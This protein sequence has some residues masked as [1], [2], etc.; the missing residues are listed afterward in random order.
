M[1]HTPETVTVAHTQYI[2]ERKALPCVRYSFA[3]VYHLSLILLLCFCL[4]ASAS[5]TPLQARKE[6]SQKQKMLIK[7]KDLRFGPGL[8]TAVISQAQ[9]FIIPVP[10]LDSGGEKLIYP[11]GHKQAGELIKDWQGN[12]VGKTGIVFFNAKD[13]SW[14]AAPGDGNAVIIINEVTEEQGR[15][16]HD[17]IREFR[18]NPDDLSLEELKQILTFAREELRLGD[19]YNSTRQF[20]FEK[21]TPIISGQEPAD[22]KTGKA[23]GLM[24]RDDRDICQ[25][26]YIPGTFVFQGPAASPQ[27]FENGGVLVKQGKDIRGVQPEVF[28]RTYRHANGRSFHNVVEE[29]SAKTP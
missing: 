8:S 21:M 24:K 2:N 16:I 25:A 22:N 4:P 12:P 28:Q 15:K 27:V 18:H 17:K 26:V 5:A 10:A 23:F 6:E 29:L 9:K 19:M 13:Q 14:Q 3:G 11:P 1:K 7:P 20:V